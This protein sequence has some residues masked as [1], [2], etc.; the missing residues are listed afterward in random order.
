MKNLKKSAFSLLAG[1]FLLFSC[2]DFTE[3][4]A[5][6]NSVLP[7]DGRAYI[8]V[9]EAGS[10]KSVR[11]AL[12][13]F[14][15]DGIADF[16]FTIKG[17][18][19]GDSG[20][21][22][23]LGSFD[24]LSDLKGATIA[25][26]SGT[27]NFTL[28]AEKDGTVLSGKLENKEIS[29]A[30]NPNQL[31]FEL[32]WDKS[33]LEGEGSLSFSLDFS[34]ASNSTSVQCATG[35][36]LKYDSESG[37]ETELPDYPETEL[38]ILDADDKPAYKAVYE[39]S[40]IDAG[41]HRIKIRLYADSEKKNL[42]IT[43]PELA[44]ITGGQES[45]ASRECNS[46]N[47]VYSI[48]YNNP[49]EAVTVDGSSLQEAYTRYSGDIVLPDLEK[50]GYT[51]EGWFDNEDC[52]GEA[53]EVIAGG[54][55]GDKVLW[56][57]LSLQEYTVT[58]YKNLDEAE[59][60]MSEQKFFY[61]ENKKLNP[62]EFSAESYNFMGW[63]TSSDG[64]KIYTDEEEVSF[65]EDTNL[66]AV[67]EP[68]A[69]Y[70]TVR[71]YQQ[72]IDDDEYTEVEEENLQGILGKESEAVAK[73]YE[74]FTAETFDQIVLT[75]NSEDN[76]VSIYY[77]RNVHSIT[78]NDGLDDLV[79]SVPEST[80]LRYG[81][82][83]SLNFTDVE[84][85]EGYV[86]IAWS[87][88]N[89]SYSRYSSA[90]LK[91]GDDDVILTAVWQEK[92]DPSTLYVDITNGTE[93]GDG[94][95]A[96]PFGN[97]QS[98]ISKIQ[99]NNTPYVDYIIIVDGMDNSEEKIEGNK[100]GLLIA[101]TSEYDS[102]TY[103]SVTS[104]VPA[105]SILIQG[106]DGTDDGINGTAYGYVPVVISTTVPVTFKNFKIKPLG[107]VNGTYNT[108]G[109]AMTI[110]PDATVTL[111]DGFELDGSDDGWGTHTAFG[112]VYVYYDATLV[113]EGNASVHN[114]SVSG[115]DS[116]HNNYGGGIFLDG[117][118]VLNGTSSVY[119]A[120]STGQSGGG[121]YV[122]SSGKLTMND[123]ASIGGESKGCSGKDGGGVYLASGSE[124]TM[125]GGSIS[126]CS[127]SLN[128]GA[129]VWVE[130]ATFT[131]NGGTIAHNTG[132]N[133][134]GGGVFVN[135]GGVFNFTGGT[136]SDNTDYGVWV[137]LY[138]SG[139]YSQ[140][141]CGKFNMSGSATVDSSN[142][143]YLYGS[144][145]VD[146]Y[147]KV[148]I[149]G[150]LT[151][152]SPVATITPQ[153]Y[154]AGTALLEVSSDSGTT[155]AAEYSKFTLSDSEAWILT[156]EGTLKKLFIGTKKPTEEKAVGDIVFSDGSATPYTDGLTLSD[157]EKAAAIAV[158]FYKGTGLNSP[159]SDGNADTET[160]RTLGLGLA[161]KN[162][163]FWAGGSNSNN[164]GNAWN[165]CV[166]ATDCTPTNFF[167]NG[168]GSYEF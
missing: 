161:Q 47:E 3:D 64:E 147:A 88:G 128:A 10:S 104:T 72:N 166:T 2:D 58:F 41:N 120:S 112:A 84:S 50:E 39:L 81:E 49:L 23:V 87:D 80:T 158:I 114:V 108:D 90:L 93:T 135:N 125:N 37:S 117:T 77:D 52:S 143:V 55:T 142:T 162:S 33:T 63:A 132:S 133:S 65:T 30:S 71:H 151:G 138:T 148:T 139:S 62:V 83:I 59:G 101:D 5:G 78:Y 70:Y 165:V 51:F 43:W 24:T 74:G 164:Y 11:T 155:L 57:K 121:I 106:K 32:S 98:A 102:E 61:G 89:N 45:S 79:I 86:L 75:E 118:L 42:I 159:D 40:A 15:E 131:M 115:K 136:I 67:W 44:I 19:T 137:G 141:L 6:E 34:K 134:R 109:Y 107:Y 66:Y 14:S 85:R 12:P 103:E 27:W 18:K 28:T 153:S 94:S 35:Q 152:T 9:R 53:L 54:S 149:A 38:S 167:S 130:G 31:S 20:P 110:C 95:A 8:C 69:A 157:D 100:A 25:L 29:T 76:E 150:S 91:M 123:S 1:L 129:G 144:S 119:S 96:K 160:E 140:D 116:N 113:M 145:T 48:T 68:I 126:Y 163:D 99:Q 60:S 154:T 22:E 122:N 21:E 82:S 4:T 16:T 146:V 92:G 17:K 56:A 7:N 127:G 97:I 36:L 13:S 156:E 111:S 105:N 73:D 46:L 26:E 124:F 168:T